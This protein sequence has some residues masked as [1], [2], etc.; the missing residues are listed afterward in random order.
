MPPKSIAVLG[1]GLTGL[2]SAFHLSRRF[3]TVKVKL[4]EKQTRLGGWV[5]SE[6]IRI[7]VKEDDVSMLLEAGP[8]TLR[9]N[10]K[11]VLELVRLIAPLNFFFGF[12]CLLAER[13]EL[14]RV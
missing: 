7:P 3:P 5:R 9:P 4:I 14:R 6:R 10:N 12:F 11:S 2:S 1:G 8:R 13:I